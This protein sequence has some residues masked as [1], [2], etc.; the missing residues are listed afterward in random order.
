[1]KKYKLTDNI[2]FLASVMRQ[3]SKASFVFVLLRIPLEVIIPYIGI[4]V[5]EFD[6]ACNRGKCKSDTAIYTGSRSRRTVSR[7]VAGEPV[8]QRNRERGV[9]ICAHEADGYAK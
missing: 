7:V 9:G 1:M 8:W 2:S 5:S 4:L 3:A 6:R